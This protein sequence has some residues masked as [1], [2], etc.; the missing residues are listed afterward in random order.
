[1]LNHKGIRLHGTAYEIAS[2]CDV[3]VTGCCIGKVCCMLNIKQ[4]T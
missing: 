1:M 3:S 4:A 2:D